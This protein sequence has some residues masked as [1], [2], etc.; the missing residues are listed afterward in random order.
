MKKLL[1]ALMILSMMAMFIGCV[2]VEDQARLEADKMS[3]KAQMRTIASAANLYAAE[4]DG[5]YPTS[6]E[7]LLTVMVYKRPLTCPLDGSEYM[8]EWSDNTFPII[9][10]PNHGIPY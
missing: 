10:C 6:W 4:N 1:L 5:R 8:I 3:C 9:E 7:E 2:D